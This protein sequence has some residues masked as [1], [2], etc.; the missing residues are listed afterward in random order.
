MMRRIGRAGNWWKPPAHPYFRGPVKKNGE[1]VILA[2]RCHNGPPLAMENAPPDPESRTL[3]RQ[4][5]RLSP[6][7]AMVSC[8]LNCVFLQVSMRV[9]WLQPYSW[10]VD[11]PSLLL[12]IGGVGL[13]LAGLVGGVWR[14]SFDTAVIATIGLVLNLG[15][16]FVVVWFFTMVN[17][18]H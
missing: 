14:R 9:A 15:I 8:A 7:A 11:W 13:G 4:L 5:A 12:V 18:H 3:S 17:H 16:V 6:L 2:A 1:M 10:L